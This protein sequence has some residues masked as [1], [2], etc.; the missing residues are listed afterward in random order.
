MFPAVRT[1]QRVRQPG[2]LTRT[3]LRRALVWDAGNSA[4]ALAARS[5]ARRGWI[6]D[7][8]GAIASPWN[9]SSCWNGTRISITGPQDPALDRILRQHPLD[10]LLLCGDD[11]VRWM[12]ARWPELPPAVHAQLPPPESLSLALSKHESMSLARRLGLPVLETLRGNSRLAV[13]DAGRALLPAR[14]EIVV[15]G[16][17]GAAGTTVFALS[18]G[19][20]PSD[21]QWRRATRLSPSVLVQ[22]RIRGPRFL[23]TV[24]YERGAERAAC[25]HEKVAAFPYAFGPTAF[26]I[27]RR[28]DLLHDYAQRLFGELQWHGIADVEFRLDR[29]DGRWYFMEINPRVCATLGIQERAG[30]DLAGAWARVC[31]AAGEECGDPR[32]YRDGVAYAWSVRAMALALRQP[33]RVPRWGW[34]CL[35]SSDS[36]QDSMGFGSR[37]RALRSSLWMARQRA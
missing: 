20:V 8:L 37:A 22:R 10:A 36:D 17:G 11:Q 6:V 31:E 33:W 13:V 29:D 25:V 26:G 23:V 9:H 5:F 19:K 24:A 2:I 1:P 7:W 32:A 27:T 28:V 15:K 12:L 4:S 3:R 34:R 18:K 21:L 35:T 16:E 14:G 30:L